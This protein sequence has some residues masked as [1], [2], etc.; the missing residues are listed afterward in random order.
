M[1]CTW[2]SNCKENDMT[3][4]WWARMGAVA[5]D[6]REAGKGKIMLSFVIYN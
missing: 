2:S 3:A 4:A 6:A 1:S 5:D